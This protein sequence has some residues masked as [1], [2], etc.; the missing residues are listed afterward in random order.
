MGD[1]QRLGGDRGC[2][3]LLLYLSVLEGLLPRQLLDLLLPLCFVAEGGQHDVVPGR[4]KR[5]NEKKRKE[6]EK[7]KR[8]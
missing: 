8:K 1:A 5:K 4:R 3:V 2:R 6:S 7:K